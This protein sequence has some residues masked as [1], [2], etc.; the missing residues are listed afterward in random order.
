MSAASPA[1]SGEPL[2]LV[3]IIARLNI[4]GPAI[5]AITLTHELQAHG[6]RTT[7]V[8]GVEEADEGTMDDIADALG[9]RP[10]RVD[11]LRRNPGWHDVRALLELIGII[12]RERPDIVHTHAAK[13]GTLGR[14]AA[15]I[16]SVGRRRPIIIHTFHGHSLNGYFSPRTAGLYRRIEWVLARVTDRLI[17]VSDEV[18]D[19]LVSL[20]VAPAAKF[21]VVALG[22]D[23]SPLV[24]DEAARA[25]ARRAI[26]EEL[27]IPAED[28]IVTLVARLVPIKRVDRFLKLAATLRDEPALRFLIVGDGELRE[29]LCVTPEARSLGDRL[30]WTGFRRDMPSIY[31]A[32]DIVVLTSDNEGT[33]VSLIE[34][35]AAGLP[36]VTTN[37][38]GAASV[39][40]HD[41]TGFLVARDDHAGLADAVRTLHRDPALI[42]RL[43]TAGSVR[44]R[45]RFGLDRLVEDLLGVYRMELSQR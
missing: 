14:V 8:R 6:Y 42:E 45:D 20:G 17:A 37:V 43:G 34:A 36:V 25:R 39:V 2:R 22:F 12:R 10:L 41:R 29:A 35:Q 21:Q 27:R 4:G 23:L 32:S 38:G 15:V 7:L 3:R 19:D 16:G 31:H 5:Q 30:S 40:E 11:S 9:V 24:V 28:R 26:R 1:G 33:P 13:G 18:R 44:S